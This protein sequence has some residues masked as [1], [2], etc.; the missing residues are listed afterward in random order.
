MLYQNMRQWVQG[1][2]RGNDHKKRPSATIREFPG[3][4]DNGHKGVA[5]AS[6]AGKKL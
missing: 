6:K 2:A 5:G 3:T 4:R 1:N